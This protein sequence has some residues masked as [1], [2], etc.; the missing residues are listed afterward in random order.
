MVLLDKIVSVKKE[1]VNLLK[2]KTSYLLDNLPKDKRDFFFENAIRKTKINSQN[3]SNSKI[4]FIAE[5]KK[6]SPSKGLIRK[7]YDVENISL[8]YKKCGASAISVLTDKNFFQGDAGD[9]K[10]A[11][12]SNLPILRKDFIIDPLQIYEAKI[13][14]ADAILLI[15]KILSKNQYIELFSLAKELGLAI[16]VEVHDLKETEIAFETKPN[17]IGINHRDLDSLN[18]NMNLTSIIAPHIKE[19][20]PNTIIVAES[21]FENKNDIIKLKS[22]LNDYIDAILIGSKLMES[23]D[24]EKTCFEI[25]N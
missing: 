17:I 1:E 13:L 12:V 15:V 18:I 6:A 14:E 3:K 2:K 23:H 7:D 8:T 5:C 9:I 16:I 22:D 4:N 11:K 19:V 20:L 25:F 24:I 10:K 21:G